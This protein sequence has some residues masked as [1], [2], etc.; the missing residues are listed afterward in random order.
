MT[1]KI[2][3]FHPSAGDSRDPK[4]PFQLGPWLVDPGR[5]TISDG[6]SET[7]LHPKAMEVLVA[8][9][10]RSPEVYAREELINQVW[11]DAFVGDEALT[12]NIRELRRAL[13]DDAKQPRFIETVP[14]RGYRLMVAVTSPDA[15][16]EPAARERRGRDWV[17]RV[18]AGVAV[19]LGL[20]V[21]LSRPDVP[22]DTADSLAPKFTQLTTTAG[23]Q[24]HPSLSPDG[25]FVVY[26]GKTDGQWNLYRR[27]LTGETAFNLTEGSTADDIHPAFSPDGERIA[28]RSEREGGGIFI[29]GATGESVQRVTDFG[30]NPTWS[31]DGTELAVSTL[32]FLNPYLAERGP[33]VQLRVV[34]ITTGEARVL[35]E[36]RAL[37]PS[38][39]PHGHRIALWGIDRDIWTVPARGGEIARVTDDGGPWRN[40]NPVWSPD[41]GHLFFA[42]DRG[43]SM[44][45][46]RIAIDEASGQARGAPEPVTT[47][48]RQVGYFSV[49]RNASRL[50]FTSIQTTA[51]AYKI[52]FDPVLEAVKDEPMPITQGSRMFLA[53]KPSPDGESIVAWTMLPEEGISIV[54][55]EGDN[56]RQLPVG[57]SRFP[58]WSP[59]GRR[60]AFNSGSTQEHNLE[61][62]TINP[63]GSALRQITDAKTQ[64]IVVEYPFWSPEGSRLVVGA[65]DSVHIFNVGEGQS[66]YAS[67]QIH[68]EQASPFS[69]F[70]WSPDGAWLA[71]QFEQDGARGIGVISLAS[72]VL[73]RLTEFGW[74]PEWLPDSRR[75]L[76]AGGE[77]IEGK[78]HLVDRIT[79]ET[80]EIYAPEGASATL[81]S[82]SMDGKNIFYTHRTQDSD[83]WLADFSLEP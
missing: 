48:A 18:G 9:G 5:N 77:P 45:L 27:R 44:N 68:G 57:P 15:H 36:G 24:T 41:G 14:K 11:R 31:P 82:I 53:P 78:L 67:L 22:P 26:S 46:W 30:F 8:L 69:P 73:T 56:L 10:E 54:G 2:H 35:V 74:F 4:R 17:P 19:A 23:E 40:W 47:P 80:R 52:R 1:A 64:P 55:V 32:R 28:F 29:M 71:G 61:A 43:G 38:W 33:N 58:R 75:I 39:S 83:I 7:R 49:S 50:V 42:S 72:G 21:W 62:W 16:D 3:P 12:G 79:H 51:H 76:F 65:S 37:Q 66:S 6:E 63:D 60:I 20:A 81:P 34:D 70:A 13:R 25:E 59:D